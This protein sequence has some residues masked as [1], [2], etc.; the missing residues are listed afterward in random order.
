LAKKRKNHDKKKDSKKS[1]KA[2][3]SKRKRKE[4]SS[5]EEEAGF[6]SDEDEGPSQLDKADEDDAESEAV[7]HLSWRCM[8]H[9]H[10]SKGIIDVLV[11][12]FWSQTTCAHSDTVLIISEAILVLFLYSISGRFHCRRDEPEAEG[13]ADW[14]C[15]CQP[16]WHACFSAG[17]FARWYVATPERFV[18]GVAARGRPLE[19]DKAEEGEASSGSSQDATRC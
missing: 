12:I 9:R 1:S 17:V 2:S 14:P 15:V 16:G 8:S 6:D 5:S 13:A 18:S 10:E 19:L 4:E 7:S 3:S 11:D